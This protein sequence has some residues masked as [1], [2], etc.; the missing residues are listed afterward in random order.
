[1]LVQVGPI[2]I[3]SSRSMPMGPY[4]L[5]KQVLY[6][7][8]MYHPFFVGSLTCVQK[9]VLLFRVLLKQVGLNIWATEVHS[10]CKSVLGPEP[11]SNLYPN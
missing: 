8:R 11:K 2:E 5:L 7:L 9:G 3:E 10:I 1:M 4:G 6:L